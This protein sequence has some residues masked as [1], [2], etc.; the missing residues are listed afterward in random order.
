MHNI[1]K[2]DYQIRKY[3]NSETVRVL[4]R[5]KSAIKKLFMIIK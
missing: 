5:Y 1:D 4:Y 3:S 2:Y